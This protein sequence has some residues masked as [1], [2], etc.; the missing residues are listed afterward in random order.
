MLLQGIPL[1]R[2]NTIDVRAGSASRRTGVVTVMVTAW[3][4]RTRIIAVSQSIY[5]PTPIKK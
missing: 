3:T 1:A 2:L 5:I 4:A